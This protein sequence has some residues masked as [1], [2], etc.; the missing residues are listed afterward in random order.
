MIRLV[1][2]ADEYEKRLY[3]EVPERFFVFWL[4]YLATAYRQ[5]VTASLDYLEPEGHDVLGHIRRARAEEALVNA[6][7]EAGLKC[8][9]QKNVRMTSNHRVAVAGSIVLVQGY[10]AYPNEPLR[11]AEHRVD[12]A[13]LVEGDLWA[14][15]ADSLSVAPEKCVFAILQHGA[16]PKIPARLGYA[17]VQFPNADVDRYL[18]TVNIMRRFGDDGQAAET[19]TPGVLPIRPRKGVDT[20]EEG[21]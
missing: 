16:H 17:V 18:S 5:A 13:S 12:Y 21:A 10:Q 9:S 1:G 20:G 3:N 7:T 4:K 2:G 11:R 6:S 8:F 14:G 15:F 19:R